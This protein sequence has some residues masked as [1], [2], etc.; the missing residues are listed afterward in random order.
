MFG[1]VDS[2]SQANI[3]SEEYARESGL[4]MQL[5]GFDDQV[6]GMDGTPAEIVG[7]IPNAE[8]YVTNS[9]I[10]TT[11][12]LLVLKDPAFSLLL[13]RPWATRN[14]AGTDETD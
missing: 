10:R 1:I 14:R 7:V 13:G 11:G 12:R 5:D 8:I 9:D 3:I 6:S 2:G 4:P